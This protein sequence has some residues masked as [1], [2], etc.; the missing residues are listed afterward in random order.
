[1]RSTE[2]RG[3]YHG[4]KRDPQP[5]PRADGPS[6]RGGRTPR[7][8]RPA[9]ASRAG[10]GRARVELALLGFG[11]DLDAQVLVARGPHR[12]VRCADREAP[13]LRWGAQEDALAGDGEAG[14][15]SRQPNPSS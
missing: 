7:G 4:R 1:M 12:G 6:R 10:G 11:S 13:G 9:P 3:A 14:G 8:E 15:V 5:R 2:R